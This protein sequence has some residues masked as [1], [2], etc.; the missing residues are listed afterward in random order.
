M[1]VFENHYEVTIITEADDE[2]EALLLNQEAIENISF[3]WRL[4]D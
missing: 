3:D 1:P 2:D 4:L